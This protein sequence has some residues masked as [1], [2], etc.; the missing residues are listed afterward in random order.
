MS[1][2]KYCNTELSKLKKLGDKCILEGNISSLRVCV[3]RFDT[4]LILSTKAIDGKLHV[5]VIKE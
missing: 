3:S 2:Q 4:D 5:I 1:V